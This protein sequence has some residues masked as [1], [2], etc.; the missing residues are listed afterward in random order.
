MKGLCFS[1]Y[2]E[3]ADVSTAWLEAQSVGEPIELLEGPQSTEFRGIILE[4]PDGARCPRCKSDEVL[5]AVTSEIAEQVAR[6]RDRR[7]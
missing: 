3:R 6:L 2:G 7:P 1:C 4:P 5:I